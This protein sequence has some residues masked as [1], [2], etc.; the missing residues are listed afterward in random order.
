[1]QYNLHLIDYA[2]WRN[3]IRA[4]YPG[5]ALQ[6]RDFGIKQLTTKYPE[7]WNLV[8]YVELG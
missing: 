6:S 3:T 7:F 5:H 1:M 8:Q 2:N 4:Y